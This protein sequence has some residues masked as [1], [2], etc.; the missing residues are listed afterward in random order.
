MPNTKSAIKELRKVKKRTARNQSRKRDLSYVVKQAL[1]AIAAGDKAA[2]TDF[3]KQ[4]QKAADKAA[5]GNV[6]AR[7][8]AN[9]QKSRIMTKLNAMK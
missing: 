5:K 2:A 3:A 9:R 1:R 8:K 7:N 4:V 6:I